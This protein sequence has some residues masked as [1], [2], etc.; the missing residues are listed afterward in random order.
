MPLAKSR[1]NKNKIHKKTLKKGSGNIIP[2]RNRKQNKV[3]IEEQEEDCTNKEECPICLTCSN[4]FCAFD[5]TVEDKGKNIELNREKH[6]CEKICEKCTEEILKKYDDRKILE[7]GT[8]NITISKNSK[9]DPLCPLCR[10]KIMNVNTFPDY[11]PKYIILREPS[12][13][14][15]N[16]NQ[17]S[18]SRSGSRSRSE[19][20][21]NRVIVNSRSIV[22][23]PDN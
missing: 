16:S 14:Q 15:S 6:K 19:R 22:P 1:K 21:R 3:E 11:K 7:S 20:I 10:G 12:T 8:I 4:P 5:V 13:P 18:R 23:G 2:K 17:R 9:N